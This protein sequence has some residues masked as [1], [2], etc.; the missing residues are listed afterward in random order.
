MKTR[1]YTLVRREA[2]DVR[3]AEAERTDLIACEYC[4]AVHQRAALALREHAS[5]LRCGS[6]LYRESSA[7]RRRM[8]PLVI[9]AL[10][11]FCLSN[12]YP[13][14]EINIKGMRAETTL[15][16]AIS[17]LYAGQMAPIAVLMFVTTI[18][19]PL[20]ELLMMLYLLLGTR[21]YRLP[22]GFRHVAHA[23]HRIRPWGMIEVYMLGML[24]TLTKLSSMAEV[25]PGI[26]LWSFG[27][28]VLVL[29][30]ML[31]FDPRDLWQ[32]V[33]PGSDKPA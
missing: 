33:R 19:F 18:L 26:A 11:L 29:A 2:A 8:L 20:A 3:T 10:I 27:L 5:C 6:P 1:P 9:A 25:V 13:I 22:W 12:L 32:Q 4:D 7:A 28:L 30:A 23:L 24:V 31:S 16:G 15:W 21:Q 14:A 17:K